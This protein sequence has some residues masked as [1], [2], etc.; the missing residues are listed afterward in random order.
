MLDYPIADRDLARRLESLSVR[1]LCAYA[2]SSARMGIY[3]DATCFRVAGGAAVWYSPDNL[4]NGS[5]GL[6]M[7]HEVEKEE[8]AALI[9][10][11]AE[12]GMKARTD[13]CPLADPSLMRW[14]AEAG[15]VATD[16]EAVLYQPLP[17]V[18]AP[19]VAEGVQVRIATTPA[20]RALWA[21]LESR[22]FT[23]EAPTPQHDELARAI[24]LREDVLHFIG[25][26]EGEPAGT[27][28]LAMLDGLAGLNGDSTLP[29]M[30]NRGV[31]SSILGE[32]LR[33]AAEAGC[34][35]AVIE[36]APGGISFRNQQRAGF[37]VAY[38]RVTLELP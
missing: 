16:F 15:F 7:G 5:F 35:L 22:G 19:P 38:T 12:R 10:F 27:G 29:A 31:Q 25:Y 6:G 11:F 8:I 9:A 21:E 23:N 26:L 20:E 3:P 4:V 1:D 24:S 32:R 28:M 13:V 17:S 37:R 33:Y 30:R 18:D 34:E 14:L 36:A 2:E